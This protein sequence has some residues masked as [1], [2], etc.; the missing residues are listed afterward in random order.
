[1][2]L[3]SLRPF[4]IGDLAAAQAVTAIG[5]AYLARIVFKLGMIGVAGGAEMLRR[6]LPGMALTAA[7]TVVGLL[8]FA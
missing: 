3:S 8:V 7:G 5:L 6:C 2:R 4:G 1:M